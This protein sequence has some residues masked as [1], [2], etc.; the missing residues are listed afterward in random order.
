MIAYAVRLIL[1]ESGMEYAFSIGSNMGDRVGG[2]IAARDGLR[3][4]LK[5]THVEQS[6]I[7][8]TEPIDVSARDRRHVF[9]NAVLILDADIDPHRCLD[10]CRRIERRAGRVSTEKVN[11]PRPLDIDIVYAGETVIGETDLTVPHPRW[12]RRRFVLRP[13]A[14]LRPDKL[15]PLASNTVSNLLDELDENAK[16]EVFREHW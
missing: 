11:A 1:W 13:L 12:S 6:P 7:Y 9:L 8:A 2:L 14:E 4:A 10:V 16:V 15:L 5:A 3:V